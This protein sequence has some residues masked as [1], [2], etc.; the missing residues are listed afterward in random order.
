[1]T[2]HGENSLRVFPPGQNGAETFQHGENSEVAFPPGINPPEASEDSRVA[3]AAGSRKRKWGA[4]GRPRKA[5]AERRSSKYTVAVNDAEKGTIEEAAKATGLAPAVYLRAVAVY[6]Q[7][8]VE[9]VAPLRLVVGVRLDALADRYE[10]ELPEPDEIETSTPPSAPASGPTSG[11][12]RRAG[13]SGTSTL[14]PRAPSKPPRST[15]SSTSAS[16]A[17][18]SR[19]TPSPSPTPASR[20]RRA[21]YRAAPGRRHL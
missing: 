6:A 5:A 2:S 8:E 19:P 20:R 16:S 4:G 13:R 18:R 1:M 17:S 21:V 9:P 14:R 15:S 10:T 7:A 3:P 12:W 11:G